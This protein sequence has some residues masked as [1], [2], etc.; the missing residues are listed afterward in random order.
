MKKI[1]QVVVEGEIEQISY[2]QTKKKQED[3]ASF[4][5][6]L[7]RSKEL[8]VKAHVNAFGETARVCK[9][10]KLTKGSSV[11]IFGEL[12]TRAQGDERGNYTTEIRLIKVFTTDSSAF[13]SIRQTVSSAI[14]IDQA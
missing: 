7:D 2:S 14:S 4:L 10:K 12:M 5:L 11:L 9:A 8:W 1:N 3:C 6:V 13:H